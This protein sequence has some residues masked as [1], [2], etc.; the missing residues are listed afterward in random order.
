MSGVYPFPGNPNQTGSNMPPGLAA[1]PPR[2]GG[3]G[4]IPGGVTSAPAF[5]RPTAPGDQ[6]TFAAPP[7]S[8]PQGQ[9]IPPQPA[10]SW[11]QMTPMEP[12]PA[13]QPPAPPAPP[14]TGLQS[15]PWYLRYPIGAYL[16]ASRLPWWVWLGVGIGVGVGGTI[17]VRRRRVATA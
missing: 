4:G 16:L 12:A 13:P 6:P 14:A 1:P 10:S 3:P 15:A 9:A 2:S 7:G 17:I 11:G 5:E 8:K